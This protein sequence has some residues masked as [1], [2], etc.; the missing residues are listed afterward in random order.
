MLYEI[1][2]TMCVVSNKSYKVFRLIIKFKYRW[3]YGPFSIAWLKLA[4][5]RYIYKLRKMGTIL[6]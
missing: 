4:E 2:V 5:G 1:C 3:Q 6:V